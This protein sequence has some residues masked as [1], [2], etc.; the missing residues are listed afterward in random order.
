[1]DRRAVTVSLT[2]AGRSL[3]SKVAASFDADIAEIMHRLPVAD[4]AALTRIVS[5]LLVAYAADQ[6]VDLFA[7]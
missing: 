3:V 6:D 5:R 1:M 2:R 4:R 7:P